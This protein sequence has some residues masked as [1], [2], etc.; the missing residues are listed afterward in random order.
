MTE[1]VERCDRKRPHTCALSDVA[2]F[3]C[4]RKLEVEGTS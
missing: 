4:L 1:K 3:V 2:R